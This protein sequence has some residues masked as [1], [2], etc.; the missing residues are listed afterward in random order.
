MCICQNRL[1]TPRKKHL[2]V[3]AIYR[4]MPEIIE[5]V[6]VNQFTLQSPS[7]SDLRRTIQRQLDARQ[8]DAARKSLMDLLRI[9]PDDAIAH[10]TLVKLQLWARQVGVARRSMLEM[11]QRLP[12]EPMFIVDLA[13]LLVS[14][15]ETVAAR[16][17]LNH[18]A[19]AHARSPQALR[20]AAHVRH[21][22][23]E[24]TDAMALMDRAMALGA[25]DPED[26]H[27]HA[28]LLQFVGRLDDAE[29][30]L[31]RCLERWPGFGS[32]AL[33][34][35][36]LRRQ[37]SS[38]NH[39][40]YLADQLARVDCASIAEAAFH[41]ALFKELNDLGRVEDAWTALEKANAIMHR[42]NPYN[43]QADKQILQ[44]TI[45]HAT[46]KVCRPDDDRNAAS[47]PT[48]IF[49]IG[50]PRSGTTLLDRMLSCHS[51]VTTTGELQDFFQQWK[52]AASVTGD[53]TED[54]MDGLRRCADV[55]FD[56]L[57]KR[58]LEQTTWR[59][60]GKRYFIDKMPN[61]FHL[62]GVIHRALPGARIINMTRDPMAICFSHFKAMFGDGSPHCYD[63]ELLA[64]HVLRHQRLHAHWHEVVPNAILDVSYEDLVRDPKDTM[65]EVLSFCGLEFEPD[66]VDPTRNRLPVTS[67][68]SAQVR[69]PIHDAGIKE[70]ETYAEHLEPMRRILA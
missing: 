23:Q 27:F 29:Q 58:Y 67:L 25:D 60:G 45:E 1:S 8:F 68:S 26:H 5:D 22:L 54:H 44:A 53:R 28:L 61:N 16:D 56:M 42:R 24:A 3:I 70:W 9:T 4:R 41:F 37:T 43:E 59:A 39:V 7:V 49:I 34:R 31:D 46:A 47:G 11:R 17:C 66:C 18:P 14:I 19:M 51:N 64:R 69:E 36:R 50:M 40:N 33:T 62:A 21:D 63:Q 55:D 35:S 2:P 13:Q 32:G 65:T 6:I 20:V 30:A 57:G 15:G 52:R 48:P 10:L 12:A 38:K